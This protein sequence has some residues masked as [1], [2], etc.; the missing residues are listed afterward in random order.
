MYI[1]PEILLLISSSLNLFILLNFSSMCKLLRNLIVHSRNNILKD[2]IIRKKGGRA[3]QE[4]WNRLAVKCNYSL[5]SHILFLK[6]I[7]IEDI[8]C[9]NL[10]ITDASNLRDI[11]SRY[12]AK[13][14]YND[15]RLL[16]ERYY[17]IK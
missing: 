15:S 2:E 6:I 4:L 14:F 12:R 17:K 10:L 3:T 13:R 16:R 5:Y 8:D 9:L 11:L 7:K 1:P